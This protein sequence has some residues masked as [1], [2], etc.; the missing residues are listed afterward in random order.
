MYFEYWGYK[1]RVKSL[2]RVHHQSIKFFYSWQSNQEGGDGSRSAQRSD[3]EVK[4]H[5][6]NL[7]D[8]YQKEN[9]IIINNRSYHTTRLDRVGTKFP[10]E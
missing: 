5:W 6:L 10:G 2:E 4:K 7:I 1:I 8:H 9:P 3:K